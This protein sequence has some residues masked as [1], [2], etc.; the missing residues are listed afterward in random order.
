MDLDEWLAAGELFLT[1]AGIIVGLVMRSP[2]TPPHDPWR[3]HV[4]ERERLQRLLAALQRLRDAADR[5]VDDAG[6]S[7]E[8]ADALFAAYE[9]VR[10]EAETTSRPD[11]RSA[12]L[13]AAQVMAGAEG[14]LLKQVPPGRED[15][16]AHET[17]RRAFESARRPIERRLQELDRLITTG[18]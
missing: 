13:D 2:V 16:D 10:H 17:I 18:R 9:A 5:R 15:L 6:V 11:I 8:A 4:A 1:V 12:A 14:L 3:G 7:G